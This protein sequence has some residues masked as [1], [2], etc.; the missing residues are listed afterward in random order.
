MPDFS[1]VTSAWPS[2]ST[3]HC[4]RS[5]PNWRQGPTG[6]SSRAG[7]VRLTPLGED[8]PAAGVV[9]S[10]SRSDQAKVSRQAPG[11]AA[12]PTIGP[13]SEVPP[14]DPSKGAPPSAKTPPSVAASQYPGPSGFTSIPAP[15]L[16]PS[17]SVSR[18]RR[19]PTGPIPPG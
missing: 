1:A 13:F 7:C 12:I 6:R 11:V 18:S 16:T 9:H 8:S 4:R 10:A 14:I 3:E 5:T 15:W 19:L 2:T 17:P